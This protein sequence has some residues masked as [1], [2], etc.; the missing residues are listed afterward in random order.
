MSNGIRMVVI[1]VLWCGAAALGAD[2]MEQV[3]PFP[4]QVHVG[5]VLKAWRFDA[6]TEG[7]RNL[8]RCELSAAGGSLKIACL[9]HDPYVGATCDLP[10]ARDMVIV[11]LRARSTNTGGGEFFWTTQEDP[12][13]SARRSRG[14]AMV[15]DG[16]WHD[17]QVALPV[18]G[19]LKQLRLDP[20]HEKGV[21]ELDYI[22]VC[23][24]GPHPLEIVR[25]AAG[26]DR[27]RGWV[28]NHGGEVR[29]VG[30]LGQKRTISPGAAAEVIWPT[31]GTAAFEAVTVEVTP[32]DAALPPLKRTTVIARPTAAVKWIEL[33][34][35]PAVGSAGPITVQVAPDGSGAL[36]RRAGRLVAMLAPIV[37]QDGR[38]PRLEPAERTGK[39]A[40]RT[41]GV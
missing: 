6:G 12:N 31:K 39:S 25:L 23:A 17:Y 40:D 2:E 1:A 7:W 13:L 10:A 36:I 3:N 18:G 41:S 35:K 5:K 27:I 34:D 19:R 20:G 24:G 32:A 8:A 14:F 21:V 28:K 29:T 26:A 30:V 16:K 15:H 9:G 38:I 33:T 4:R 11:R 37:L 22:E